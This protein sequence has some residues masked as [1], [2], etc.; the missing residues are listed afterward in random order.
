V[1]PQLAKIALDLPI[2]VRAPYNISEFRVGL[3]GS[4]TFTDTYV[5]VGLQGDIVPIANPVTP[6]ITPPD[7]PPFN[8]TAA[9]YYLQVRGRGG[10]WKAECVVVVVGS[11]RACRF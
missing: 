3:T 9:S 11:K 7:L 10:A 6:P 8:P 2:H 5:G 1:N 4:P